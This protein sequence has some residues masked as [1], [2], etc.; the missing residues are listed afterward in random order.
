MFAATTGGIP[1]GRAVLA[2]AAMLALLTT[3]GYGQS[4]TRQGYGEPRAEASVNPFQNLSGSW[5]GTGTVTM[6]DGTQERIRC[7]ARYAV[8][9]GGNALRQEL[10]CASAGYN[11]DLSSDLLHR[12]GTISGQWSEATRNT[13]GNLSGSVT[14]GGNIQAV[15][16]GPGFSA[17]IS[18]ATRGSRQ[19]VQLVSRGQE[20]TQVSITLNRT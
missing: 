11:F 17:T 7:R 16:D 2:A 6:S 1:R 19:S 3:Q 9:P 18:V 14:S 15:V 12:G 20:V 10:R 13:G 5:A 8:E 4:R